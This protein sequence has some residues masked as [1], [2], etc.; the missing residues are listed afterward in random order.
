MSFVAQFLH[1]ESFFLLS[2]KIFTALHA[3]LR[4]STECPAFLSLPACVLLYPSYVLLDYGCVL[5]H[6]GHD[7]L[8]QAVFYRILQPCF[9]LP[10]F[11]RPGCDQPSCSLPTCVL[12]SNNLL[13]FSA[14]MFCFELLRAKNL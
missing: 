9:T 4:P 7:H 12:P 14:L 1:D 10:S 13:Y 8:F 6:T 11:A 5:L 2:T 3:K